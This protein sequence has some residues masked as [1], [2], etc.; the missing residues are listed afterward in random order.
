MM[1]PG[2]TSLRHSFFFAATCITAASTV[3]EELPRFEITPL[4]GQ[5]IEMAID[6]EPRAAWHF[7]S[8]T[9]RPFFFPFTSPEGGLLTRMGHPGA[10]NHDHHLSIWFAH[11]DVDGHSFWQDE[12]GCT[13]RQQFWMVQN[14][15]DEEGVL[16][17]RLAWLD[18][19]GA[20]LLEHDLVAALRPAG[21]G[22]HALELQSTF[23]PATGRDRVTL[24]KTNF[25]FLAVRVAASLSA[26]FGNGTITN[27]EGLVG[28]PAIFGER[29]T[30]VDYSGSVAVG[31]GA[32]RHAKPAGITSIDHP[33]NPH[34]P[35]RWHVRSDGWM[36][37]S[38]CFDAP[39]EIT[40]DAPL[41]LRYLLYAHRGTAAEATIAT[42]VDAFHA[43]P[44]WL[45]RP[46][47]G[48]EP[49]RQWIV[50]RR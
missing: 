21:D 31:H 15:S 3:A 19:T 23:R 34:Y 6:G 18:P 5:T 16:A 20:A 46:A 1:T 4:P 29:A 45:I 41:T 50:E 17:V 36:G 30:W 33:D 22:E 24:G 32:T 11:H 10:E 12:S 37:A 27:S 13:I 9:P 25:G 43:R 2:S 49:H 26:F 7:A 14:S 35:T 28:E 47:T 40:S 38:L 39:Y 44:G 42:V 48:S 8:D